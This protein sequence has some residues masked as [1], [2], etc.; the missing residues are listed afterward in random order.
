MKIRDSRPSESHNGGVSWYI[1]GLSEPRSDVRSAARPMV[2]PLIVENLMGRSILLRYG[3]AALA[4]ILAALI[5]LAIDPIVGDRFPAITYFIALVF[6]AWYGGFGPSLFALA[7]SVG[8]LY[9][10]HPVMRGPFTLWGLMP[11]VGMARFLIVG[12]SVSLLGGSVRIAR[13]RAERS[14]REAEEKHRQLELEIAERIQTEE[15]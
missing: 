9:L 14:A 1:R 8:S 10:F 6:S 15:Q 7:L 5:R 2:V 12:I 11:R 13:R 4:V 3:S